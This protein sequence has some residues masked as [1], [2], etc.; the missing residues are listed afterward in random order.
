MPIP[1]LV[2][3]VAAAVVSFSVGYFWEDVIK[4]WAIQAAGR[5]LDYI[6]SRLK[7]FSEAIVSLTKKGRDYIAE[8][9][10]Y[11][12]DKKSGE[13]EVE[14][15]K[16]RISASEIPDDILSQLEQQKKI[17]VGRIGTKR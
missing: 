13:Y 10:V 7:Y 11:T 1:I 8:L 17:E 16:K 15:E 12:Q 5:I 14:T 6:D 9:K 3:V 2:W 4:P